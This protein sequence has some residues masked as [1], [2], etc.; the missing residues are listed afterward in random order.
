VLKIVFSGVVLAIKNEL[1][2]A[3]FLLRESG[4][5]VDNRVEDSPMELIVLF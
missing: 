5:C 2:I 1:P 3:C 4:L